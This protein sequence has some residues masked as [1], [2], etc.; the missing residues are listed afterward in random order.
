MARVLSP[1]GRL[2]I[3]EF[4]RPGRVF[5][6]YRFPLRVLPRVG[7]LLSGSRI[8]AYRYLPDS[9]WAFAGARELATVLPATA[10]RA[11]APAAG[12]HRAPHV[13]EKP[14]P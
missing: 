3:L 13:A 2:L 5:G 10:L 11:A 9:V 4:S 1:G 6:R 7:R 14:A 8:D 12:R